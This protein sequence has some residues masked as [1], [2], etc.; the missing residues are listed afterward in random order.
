[1]L[2]Y[3][4]ASSQ[5]GLNVSPW[6]KPTKLL[7]LDEFWLRKGKLHNLFGKLECAVYATNQRSP[8]RV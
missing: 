4:A 7:S 8:K 1:M 5:K 2:Q 3:T 6:G